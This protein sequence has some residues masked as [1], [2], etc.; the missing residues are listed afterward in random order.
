MFQPTEQ[1][2]SREV[3]GLKELGRSSVFL[4]PVRQ[5]Q[6]KDRILHRLGETPGADIRSVVLE[7]RMTLMRYI[8]SVLVGLGLVGGTAFA[9]QGALP[10]EVLYPVKRATEKVELAAAFTPTAQARVNARQ[11]RERLEELSEIRVRLQ[12]SGAASTSTATATSPRED[13]DD[14]DSVKTEVELKAEAEARARLRRA[15]EVLSQVQLELKAK[16][17]ATAAAALLDQ[18]LKLELKADELHLKFESDD[19]SD[20]ESRGEDRRDNPSPQGTATTSTSTSSGTIREREDDEDRRGEDRD[21]DRDD[22]GDDDDGDDDGRLQAPL[23]STSPAV[24]VKTYTFAE[25]QAAGSEAKCWTVISGKVYNLTPW[26]PTHPGGTA[27][28]KGLCGKDGTQAF[29]AQHSGQSRPESTLAT[30]QIGVLL[31]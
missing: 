18:V 5:A 27:A 30:F 24:T 15:V 12:A 2:F 10:G 26:I 7:R 8:V 20:D 25:V 3:A 16:G 11:A 28:I 17:Q 6:L 14:D 31:K 19:D 21:D 1:K 4:H 13:G 23:P 9:S 22:D 29:S